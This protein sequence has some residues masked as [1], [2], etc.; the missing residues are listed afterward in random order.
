MLIRLEDGMGSFVVDTKKS[1]YDECLCEPI[2][3]P[4][5]K[6]SACQEKKK[7]EVVA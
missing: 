2:L 7:Q 1:P 6:C 3:L 4:N 5:F